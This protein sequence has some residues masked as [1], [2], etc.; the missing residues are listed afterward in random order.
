V[1][2]SV[3]IPCHNAGPY[4][5]QTIGSALDQSRPPQEIIVVDDGSTDGSL[6]VARRFAAGCDGVVRVFA[7]CSGRASRTRSIGA[8]LATGDALMF[9]DAD[10]VLAP[11]VFEA[12]TDALSCQP[13]SIA[14][15][16]W[17]RLQRE[18][19]QW[20]SRP[21]SCIARSK[22]QDVLGAWL[23]GW[24]YPTCS[25]LWSREAFIRTGGWDEEATLNDDGDLVM[26][27]LLMGVPLVESAF[28]TSYYRKLPDGQV[29]LTSTR[30][31]YGGLAGRLAIR[32][33][34]ARLLEEQQ[35]INAYRA[36]ISRS[37]ALIAADAAGS[38]PGLSQ[39]A[40]QRSRHFAPTIGSR[41]WAL[42][43][44]RFL[45]GKSSRPGASRN[46]VEE[47]RFG[48]DAAAR[49]LES[50][51]N[52]AVPGAS[53]SLPS[54][55]R[56]TV[57]VVIA[58]CKRTQQLPKALDSVLNQTFADFEIL[59][60]DDAS[61]REPASV[62]ASYHDARLRYFRQSQ[63]QSVAAAR[64][65]GLREARASYVAF[66]DD[67]DEWFPKK[68][69]MQVD[70]FRRSPTDVG[71]IYTGS[72]SVSDGGGAYGVYPY[73]ARA[74]LSGVSGEEPGA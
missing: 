56:P 1:N 22:N 61:S 54:V 59:V 32:E 23:S 26:R 71:M 45:R 38:Y 68:L 8:A 17:R 69:E 28:G 57:S 46:R 36:P 24:Y 15:C 55:Q 6:A 4:L 49:V 5:A 73:R 64:N 12:L 47:I 3:I 7:E 30:Y 13:G 42:A 16:G 44:Q 39:Q 18:D 72:E 40:W 62:V 74:P 27:A 25:V 35:V 29:S 14:A 52:E 58:T 50:A 60:V 67:H 10:D 53:V 43:R 31:T 70:L 41:L 65:R 21:A 63:N 51:S 20:M 9:L 37:F 19:G 66:L 34:I 11:D 33:K 48:L 2:V